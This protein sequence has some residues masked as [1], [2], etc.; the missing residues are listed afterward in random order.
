MGLRFN[1]VVNPR[2]GEGFANDE[3]KCSNCHK[4]TVVYLNLDERY[5]LCKSCLTNFIS[6]IDKGIANS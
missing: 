4:T 6:E 1:L 5:L 3:I 2:L